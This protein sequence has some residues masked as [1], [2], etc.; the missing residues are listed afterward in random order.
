M[1][2]VGTAQLDEAL[3]GAE[4]HPPILMFPKQ[5]GKKPFVL[6]RAQ[7]PQR[8]GRVNPNERHVRGAVRPKDRRM[9]SSPDAAEES[10]QACRK[11][12]IA[13]VLRKQRRR[14][15]RRRPIAEPPK[16]LRRDHAH[17]G[18]STR[19]GE[20]VPESGSSLFAQLS[21]GRRRRMCQ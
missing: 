19:I 20:G 18:G 17:E 4:G 5:L 3:G 7:L 9:R 15:V 10:K 8:S 12:R 13:I 11:F 1:N 6:L 21:S 14:H 16:R 2:Y